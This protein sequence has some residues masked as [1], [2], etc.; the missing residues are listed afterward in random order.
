MDPLTPRRTSA[1]APRRAANAS[2]APQS[3]GCRPS[4]ASIRR[5]RR[6]G[7][8]R[9]S[10]PSSCSRSSAAAPCASGGRR[11][12]RCRGPR[13]RARGRTSRRST[14]SVGGARAVAVAAAPRSGHHRQGRGAAHRPGGGA[15]AS[16]RRVRVLPAAVRAHDR[17]AVVRAARAGGGREVRADA[18]PDVDPAR[19]PVLLDGVR[20]A[21]GEPPEGRRRRRRLP[22]L[23][24]A[25]PPPR[26]VRRLRLGRHRRRRG[27]RHPRRVREGGGER[28]AVPVVVVGPRRRPQR[29]AAQEGRRHVQVGAAELVA[30]LPRDPAARALLLRFRRAR[31]RSEGVDRALL[32]RGSRLAATP[33]KHAHY[34][35]VACSQSGLVLKLRASSED[36]R[37]AWMQALNAS[38]ALPS[39][40]GVSA[41]EIGSFMETLKE[42]SATLDAVAPLAAD[43]YRN[44]A[45]SP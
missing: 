22:P 31:R 17:A 15:V 32:R 33:H 4:R 24:R 20:R 41:Q 14:S 43:E 38:A 12:W 5:R 9:T 19:A 2:A 39:P 18:L 36:E 29:L 11:R 3:G 7:P 23:L 21:A 28:A 8:S 35:E 13:S 42:E 44:Y 40:P 16:A 45:R 37:V 6:P 10:A 27:A 25:A 26:A 30:P 34:F 1:P